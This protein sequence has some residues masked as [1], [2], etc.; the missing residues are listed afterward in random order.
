MPRIQTL[1]CSG[2]CFVICSVTT[3]QSLPKKNASI[4]QVVSY[5]LYQQKKWNYNQLP[6]NSIQYK[7]D[8]KYIQLRNRNVLTTELHLSSVATP[9][10]KKSFSI[11][12]QPS[13]VPLS[14][15]LQAVPSLNPAFRW[16]GHV[17]SYVSG[18]RPIQS[19]RLQKI[20]GQFIS[21]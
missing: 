8:P 12:S 13:R 1:I 3:A 4:N 5:Q 20:R 21:F 9:D 18:K 14:T 2:I 11:S 16:N 19:Q 6:K 15:Y 17:G 10:I 7:S